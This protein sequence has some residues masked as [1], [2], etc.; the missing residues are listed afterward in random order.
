M[1]WFFNWLNRKCRSAHDADERRVQA[2]INLS[3]KRSQSKYLSSPGE[4]EVGSITLERERA[5]RFHVFQATGGRIVET[6]RYDHNH[7]RNTT[8]LYVIT[9]DQ[10]FGRELDKIIT[11]EALKRS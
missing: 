7:D 3:S 10:D 8:G 4:I 1:N 6:Q 11:M 5:L 9:S 2:P